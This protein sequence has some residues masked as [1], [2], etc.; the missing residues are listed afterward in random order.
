MAEELLAL[1]LGERWIPGKDADAVEAVQIDG[2]AS[3]ISLGE[4]EA[5]GADVK[6]VA[7]SD[8]SAT[9]NI[10][11][12]MV[13]YADMALGSRE[14]AEAR[15]FSIKPMPKGMRAAIDQEKAR[16]AA[17]DTAF[18]AKQE[19]K[20]GREAATVD[21]AHAS[22][23]PSEQPPLSPYEASVLS[24][25]AARLRPQA[26]K[27]LLSIHNEC[28]L[29]VYQA[30]ALLSAIPA[31]VSEP[32]EA[33]TMSYSIHSHADAATEKVIVR[34]VEIR[35][36]GLSQKGARG[37]AAAKAESRRLNAAIADY[38]NGTPIGKALHT[39]GADVAAISDAAKRALA[40]A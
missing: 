2:V 4:A 3:P 5:M 26:A 27:L 25:D 14:K 37:D 8:E 10:G 31:E 29:P 17:E 35:A 36:L 13:R 39:A 19:Q 22:E 20:L 12:E 34:S 24:T 18:A 33:P 32:I 16:W 11:R 23:S 6:R 15:G 38:R 1:A 30:E 28:T 21:K 9:S 40:A 7:W